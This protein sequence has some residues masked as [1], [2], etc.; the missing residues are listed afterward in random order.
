MSVA[1]RR[2]GDEEH[3]EPRFE[4]P[5]PPGPNLVTRR[6]LMLTEAKVAELE[7][8]LLGL[9]DGSEIAA[10]RRQLRYWRTRRATAEL[11]EIPDGS[12]VAFGCQVTLALNGRE[13]VITIVGD[14][15]ALPVEGFLSFSAPMSRA[16]MDAEV[17]DTVEFAGRADAIEI[18][19]ITVPGD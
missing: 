10:V 1:F 7:A 3:L 17:G 16:I 4:L 18:L 19:G 6:G 13:R 14:D 5:I 12:R 2:D 15:E 9:G 8:E 11:A